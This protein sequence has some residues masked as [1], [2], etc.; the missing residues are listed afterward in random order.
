[1]PL[2]SPRLGGNAS[3]AF[4]LFFFFSFFFFKKKTCPSRRTGTV[5]VSQLH[6]LALDL[7]LHDHICTQDKAFLILT[8]YRVLSHHFVLPIYFINH[9]K[10]MLKELCV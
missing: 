5:H 4:F 10:L 1:M 3:E 2:I 6:I 9:T 8:G 7:T